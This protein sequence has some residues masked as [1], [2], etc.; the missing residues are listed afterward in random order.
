M[1]TTPHPHTANAPSTRAPYP[2][3]SRN[4][5]LNTR[6]IHPKSVR[7]KPLKWEGDCRIGTLCRTL[8]RHNA[9]HASS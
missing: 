1:R 3:Y 6:F 9:R 4:A 7:H 8:I 5:N 2:T